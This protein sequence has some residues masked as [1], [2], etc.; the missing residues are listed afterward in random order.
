[1]VSDSTLHAVV[2]AIV[3]V[4]VSFLPFSPVVGGAV[5]GYLEGPDTDQG[6]RVGAISGVFASIPLVL[7]GLALVVFGSLFLG[8]GLGIV[9]V[10]LVVVFGGLLLGLYTVGLSAIG[11][12]LGAYVAD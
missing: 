11:G 9:G 12:Y 8:F 4:L 3:T 5:A 10:L 6:L 2:G 1:M 7:L